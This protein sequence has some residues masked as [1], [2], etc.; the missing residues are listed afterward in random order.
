MVCLV[1]KKPVAIIFITVIGCS[2]YQFNNLNN[3]KILANGTT[4]AAG[5]FSLYGY[6]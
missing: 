3:I 1:T 2:F 4:I 6:I 5:T